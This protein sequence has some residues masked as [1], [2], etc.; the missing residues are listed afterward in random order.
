MKAQPQDPLSGRSASHA[1][2][3]NARLRP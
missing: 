1:S 3:D 2:Q